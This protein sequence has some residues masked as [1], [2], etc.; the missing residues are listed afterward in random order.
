MVVDA[1]WRLTGASVGGVL[2]VVVTGLAAD[3]AG[4][5]GGPAFAAPLLVGVALAAGIVATWR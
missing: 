3:A 4:L 1:N 5:T 2:L